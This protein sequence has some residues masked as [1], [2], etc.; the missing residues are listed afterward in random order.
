MVIFQNG[1]ADSFNLV[2]PQAGCVGGKD[3][4][5]EYL[6]VRQGAALTPSQLLPINVPG[7]Q[8]CNTFGVHSAMPAVKSLYDQGE[9]AFVANVGALVEPVTKDD[10]LQR[11]GVAKRYPPSLFAHNI[12]QRSL[13]NLHAQ[14]VSSKGILGRTVNALFQQSEPFASEL[15]S[16]TGNIKVL[17]ICSPTARVCCSPFFCADVGGFQRAQHGFLHVWHPPLHAVFAPPLRAGQLD[18]DQG[19]IPSQRHVRRTLEEC[20]GKERGAW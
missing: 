7:A 18:P 8:P 15:F 12:M 6:T 13:Q 20:A 19:I 17:A 14:V 9:L 3:Y 5:S 2:V 11:S 16:L 10:F 1:G 4:Y